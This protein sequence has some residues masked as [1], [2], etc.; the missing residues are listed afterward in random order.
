MDTLL[1]CMS[2]MFFDEGWMPEGVP[3]LD[4]R[5]IE[6]TTAYCSPEA[7]EQILSAIAPYPVHAV[8]LIDNGDYHYI[9]ALWMSRLEEETDLLLFDNHPDD[10]APAFG[11]DLLSCGGWVANVKK[12]NPMFR[13]NADSV[14]ISIDLDCLSP[15]YARTNWDQGDA[16]LDDLLAG[17]MKKTAGRR[18]AGVDICGGITALQG[19]SAEDYATNRKTREKLLDCFRA[20]WQE[21]HNAF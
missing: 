20:V 9:T 11:A 3:C 12:D 8:H 21:T 14:Y 17:I 5:H 7:K 1:M 6:G 16:T 2:N 13:K 10:Q 15:S 18:I 19:G 4:L